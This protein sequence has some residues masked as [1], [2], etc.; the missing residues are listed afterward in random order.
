MC[1]FLGQ[2]TP[3]AS[4]HPFFLFSLFKKMY[5]LVFC[6]FLAV[7]GLHFCV[8]ASSS[9]SVQASHFSGFS[10]QVWALGVQG[11]VAG[12]TWSQ[13][14]CGMW[15]LPNQGLNQC[16]LLCKADSQ[17]MDHQ[18]SPA[19]SLLCLYWG[20]V[21]E[22][23][24]LPEKMTYLVIDREKGLL[25]PLKK[26]GSGVRNISRMSQHLSFSYFMLCTYNCS[27]LKSFWCGT[28]G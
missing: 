12:G 11:S 19:S 16:P 1:V 4:S 8:Q 10:C 13:L 24:V 18:E 20:R 25:F 6:L 7:L 3:T 17:P 2:P 27:P 22:K 9:C 21:G 5:L 14:P 15:N 26:G 28:V 23:M